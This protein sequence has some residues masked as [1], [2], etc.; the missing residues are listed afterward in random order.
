VR[1]RSSNRPGSPWPVSGSWRS[2]DP[3]VARRLGLG[4]TSQK[5]ARPID[6]NGQAQPDKWAGNRSRR[7][8]AAGRWSRIGSQRL[9]L[10]TPR[11]SFGAGVQANGLSL[12]SP[13]LAAVKKRV[14]QANGAPVPQSSVPP[15][16]CRIPKMRV[17][18]GSS[19][20]A[21]GPADCRASYRLA[22]KERKSGLP[23]SPGAA[24]APGTKRQ[25]RGG[26]A[27]TDLRT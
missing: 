16:P 17:N 19:S 15:P 2:L 11:P 24:V 1:S 6:P 22:R 25:E 18:L 4:S 5:A 12:R 26:P 8:S 7:T 27:G 13:R 20:G 3:P 14:S 10:T 23:G 9:V 21:G